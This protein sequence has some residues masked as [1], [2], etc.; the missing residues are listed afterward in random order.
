M[1]TEDALSDLAK[2]HVADKVIQ[3][4]RAVTQ[5]IERLSSA[6]SIPVSA[7]LERANRGLWL[8]LLAGINWSRE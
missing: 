4:D 8:K 6:Q 7:I 1:R 5:E 2:I 3:I